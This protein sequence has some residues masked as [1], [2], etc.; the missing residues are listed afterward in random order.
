MSWQLLSTD[1]P[2]FSVGSTSA[3]HLSIF[4]GH[5]ACPRGANIIVFSIQ[6]T[7]ITYC[8]LFE[9][10]KFIYLYHVIII[11]NIISTWVDQ[12]VLKQ[13]AYLLKYTSELNQRQSLQVRMTHCTRRYMTS[14]FDDVM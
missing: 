8:I 1:Q 5:T 4:I 3:A 11:S 12:K 13:V 6:C 10:P 7:Y 2:T 14:S 9:V